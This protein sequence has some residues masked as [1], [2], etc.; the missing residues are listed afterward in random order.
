MAMPGSTRE[1]DSVARLPIISSAY[2]AAD[3]LVGR[4]RER[5][6]LSGLIDSLNVGG[7]AVVILGEPGMGK[8]SLLGSVADYAKRHDV[9]VYSVRGIESEE[10]LPFAAITDLLLPL[11]Q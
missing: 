10:V 7:A 1:L 11:Q 3:F 2:P 8:T 9:Q 6:L 5:R 4:N